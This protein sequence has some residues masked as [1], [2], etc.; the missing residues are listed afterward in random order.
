MHFEILSNPEFLAEG[1]AMADLEKP[2]RVSLNPQLLGNTVSVVHNVEQVP[3]I[4]PFSSYA[5]TVST[6][7][8]PFLHVEQLTRIVHFAH[9]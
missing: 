7:L 2:D 6:L 3:S 8:A 4:P 9:C 1:T 5:D